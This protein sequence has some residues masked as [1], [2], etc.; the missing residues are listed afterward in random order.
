ML[1]TY[2][3]VNVFRIYFKAVEIYTYIFLNIIMLSEILNLDLEDLL[4]VL[5]RCSK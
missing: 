5:V 1:D 4:L 2:L 3:I